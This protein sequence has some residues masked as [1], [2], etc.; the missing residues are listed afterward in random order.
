MEEKDKATT[1]GAAE[2]NAA[3]QKSDKSPEELMGQVSQADGS[4]EGEGSK[5][6]A[7]DA[8]ADE[9]NQNQKPEET[10]KPVVK[11]TGLKRLKSLFNIYLL[12]FILMLVAAGAV[13]A[14]TYTNLRQNWR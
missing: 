12:L 8:M 11:A 9:S 7:V 6:S 1:P 10:S 4:L 13:F 3:D 14:V 2:G 5:V